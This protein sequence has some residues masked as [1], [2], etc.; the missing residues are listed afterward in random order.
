[1]QKV[2]GFHAAV[3]WSLVIVL[4]ILILVIVHRSTYALATGYTAAVAEG[5]RNP[6]PQLSAEAAQELEPRRPDATNPARVAAPE[7]AIVAPYNTQRGGVRDV[8][9]HEYANY[10]STTRRTPERIYDAAYAKLYDRIVNDYKRNL[11]GYEVDQVRRHTR[12]AEY[13]SRA[14]VLDIGCGTGWHV[15]KFAAQRIRCVGL[16]QSRAMLDQARRNVGGRTGRGSHAARLVQ[17]DMLDGNTFKPGEFTHATLFYFT[18]YYAPDPAKL[19]RNVERWLKP[20]GWCC[21]HIVDPARFDPVLDA[22]NPIVGISRQRYMAQRQVESKV[23]LQNCIYRARFELDR[24][25]HRS[26]FVETIVYPQRRVVRKNEHALAMPPLRAMVR[27]FRRAGF[28]M[29]RV[30]HLIHLGYE[31]QY[32]CVLQKI[33]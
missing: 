32:L 13:G 26:T 7:A 31:Y 6:P 19:L 33:A 28:K 29:R 14:N 20:G 3:Q 16:E 17:G 4:L 27:M 1:M 25:A 8:P 21:V 9:P 22:A 2:A 12:L 10:T 5:F 15:K 11:M 23:F 18:L 24:Q 30:L